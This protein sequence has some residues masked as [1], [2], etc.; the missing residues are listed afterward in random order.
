MHRDL[1]PENIFVDKYGVIK[2]GD[3]GFA[4]LIETEDELGQLQLKK[5]PSM[6]YGTKIY[7]AP[8][9]SSVWDKNAD[10]YSLGL[11]LFAN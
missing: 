9:I 11:I 10:L 8:E 6:T 7:A 1:K 2:I 3:F 5:V 4:K